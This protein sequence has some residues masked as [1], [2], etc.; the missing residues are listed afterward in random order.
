M[1][2]ETSSSFKR[3]VF[4]LL[5]CPESWAQSQRRQSREGQR[6][7]VGL[8]LDTC[9]Q[10]RSRPHQLT[11]FCSSAVQQSEGERMGGNR[12]VVPICNFIFTCTLSQ[13][14]SGLFS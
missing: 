6:G 2:K 4:C 9:G 7:R 8:V 1:S 14:T 12:A 10:T 13:C 11:Q 3:C 5:W